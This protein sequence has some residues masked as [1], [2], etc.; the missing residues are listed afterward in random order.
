MPASAAAWMLDAHL[1][2]DNKK[3]ICKFAR[4][5]DQCRVRDRVTKA[6][7]RQTMA[8]KLG[9]KGKT[10]NA[11]RYINVELI[12]SVRKYILP[13]DGKKKNLV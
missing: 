7:M 1:L 10:L 9:I 13:D 11:C 12:V 4:P 2:G 8:Y 5:D 6:H 3:P